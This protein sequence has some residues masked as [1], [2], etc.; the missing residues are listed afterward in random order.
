MLSMQ[1]IDDA[2]KV[3]DI[4]AE[5]EQKLSEILGVKVNLNLQTPTHSNVLYTKKRHYD[6]DSI[7]DVCEHA[8]ELNKG[9]LVSPNRSNNVSE[10]RQ[11]AMF[12]IR[13]KI[14]AITLVMIGDFFN[15]DHS[16]VIYA[17][18]NA[19]NLLSVDRKVQSMYNRIL[20]EIKEVL[21]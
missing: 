18:R 4:L 11:L 20:I 13:E 3:M 7:V 1:C 12:I 15:R 14:P 2:F 16:S 8:L 10:A 19:K 5:S 6:M 9:D 17:I 21:I